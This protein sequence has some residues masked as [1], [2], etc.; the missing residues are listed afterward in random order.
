MAV[1]EGV[2]ADVGAG[3][4]GAGCVGVGVLVGKGLAVG[5]GVGGGAS[6]AASVAAGVGAALAHA[7]KITAIRVA[8]MRGKNL[9]RRDLAGWLG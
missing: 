9:G 6:V 5:E 4:V 3:S 1:G 8:R 2:T 7:A